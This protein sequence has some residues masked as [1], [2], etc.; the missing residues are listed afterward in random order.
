MVLRYH[1]KVQSLLHL[2][3][4]I[5]HNVDNIVIIDITEQNQLN[6]L[7]AATPVDVGR[8][9]IEEPGTEIFRNFSSAASKSWL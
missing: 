2:C 7:V 1:N 4:E 5:Q 3:K 8:E 9:A 6:E